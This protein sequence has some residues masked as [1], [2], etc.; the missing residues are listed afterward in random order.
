MWIVPKYGSISAYNLKK[1]EYL[2]VDKERNQKR[3]G[4]LHFNYGFYNCDDLPLSV[5]NLYSDK[6][7]R[8][9]HW[10][11]WRLSL[12]NDHNSFYWLI[13]VNSSFYWKLY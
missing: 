7:E 13:I 1:I 3:I 5:F 2:S 4:N 11:S 12:K 8:W 6:M 9:F 10:W